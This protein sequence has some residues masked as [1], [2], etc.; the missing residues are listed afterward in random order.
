MKSGKKREITAERQ[1]FQKIL[2]DPVK[3]TLVSF[4]ILT[5]LVFGVFSN[6]FKNRFT[7]W[8]DIAVYNDTLIR[9]PSLKN[10]KTI[11]TY[12]RGSTYQPVRHISFMLDYYL[13]KHNPFCYHFFNVVYY[14]FGVLFLYLFTERLLYFL[15]PWGPPKRYLIALFSTIIFAVHPVHVESVAWISARKEGLL[16]WFFCASL[17]FYLKGREGGKHAVQ[18]FFWSF[19]AFVLAVL[20][21]PSAVVLPAILLLFEICH[22]PKEI[23]K[24]LA[25]IIPS[26][27]VAGIFIAILMTVMKEAGGIKPY[28]GGTFWTNFLVSFF[29]FLNYIK[30]CAATINYSA[31][32]TIWLPSHPWSVWTFLA[33]LINLF[34]L[35]IGIRNY[36]KFPLVT[37]LIFWFYIQLLPYSNIIPIS[38]ILADR[39]ALLASFS[40]TLLVGIFF[41][42]LMCLRH[43]KFTKEFFK[44]LSVAIF[45]LLTAG[46]S[47]MTIKQNRVWHDTRTLWMDAY[48]KYPHAPAAQHGAALVFMKIGA[49][50]VAKNI[51]SE[52]IKIQPYD[53]LAHNN[54]GICYFHLKDYKHALKEYETALYYDPKNVKVQ[55]NMAMLFTSMGKFRKADKIYAHLLKQHPGNSNWHLRRAYNFYKWGKYGLALKEL[56]TCIRLTP[57]VINPYEVM[58]IIYYENLHQPRLA[59]QALEAGLKNAPNS[60]R[61]KEVKKKLLAIRKAVSGE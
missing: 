14:L 11:F 5:I 26:I 39:Y 17:Y 23:K 27:V 46:Y 16:L 30:L 2:D 31:A 13:C 32:Y 53:Y 56:R 61:A 29:I 19:V 48:E 25:I 20:S 58:A 8:D 28:R 9:T 4:V 47:Y 1:G 45:V 6:T 21:K 44:V 15:G 10:I 41:V 59:I 37:F 35:W 49:Y 60:P 54:L 22:N 3:M 51:L 12:H 57:H 38:T 43:E 34:I 7:T 50:G 52:T 42:W 33:I 18:M 55:I 36:K 24:F 40:Y